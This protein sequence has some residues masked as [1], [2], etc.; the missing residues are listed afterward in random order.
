MAD[1]KNDFRKNA[2]TLKDPVDPKADQKLIKH[3][4]MKRS[5]PQHPGGP[6]TATVHP[7]EVRNFVEA[8][9]FEE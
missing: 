4:K 8:G 3:V 5:H 7:A 1:E 2:P 6:T 9:W